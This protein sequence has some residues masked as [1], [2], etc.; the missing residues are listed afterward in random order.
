MQMKHAWLEVGSPK[1][2]CPQGSEGHLGLPSKLSIS[3]PGEIE[4]HLPRE[5]ALAP[6]IGSAPHWKTPL[7]GSA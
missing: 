6:R 4:K 1:W 3:F 2:P 5:D 7:E